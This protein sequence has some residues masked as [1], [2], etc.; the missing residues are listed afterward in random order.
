MPVW[1]AHCAL[2]VPNNEY[3][4]VTVQSGDR[5][6]INRVALTGD[7][8][9]AEI[10]GGN[11]SSVIL[12]ACQVTHSVLYWVT[13]FDTPSE[14]CVARWDD[15]CKERQL[16]EL[17]STIIAKWPKMRV[18]HLRFNGADDLELEGWFMARHDSEGPQPTVMFIHGGPYSAVGNVFRFDFWLLAANG[19]GVLFIN[20]RGSLGYGAAFSLAIDPDWGNNGFPDHIAAVDAAVARGLADNLRLGVWGASHGGFAT[21]WIVGHTNRFKAAVAEASLP[22]F[23]IAYYLSDLPDFFAH[24]LGGTPIECPSGYQ[25]RS[26][27]TYAHQCKTPTLL[28]HGEADIRCPIAGAESFFRALLDAGCVTELVRLKACDHLGDS[29]GPLSARLGQNQALLSWFKRYL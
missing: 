28:L 14:L 3:A 29:V 6:T 15:P 25:A 24:L 12:D 9:L 21:A 18:E 19:F 4:F 23:S 11:R 13:G 22:D 27:L 1:D 8:Q 17:N 2:V 5:S 7:I 26:P 20:F 10:V 16:T